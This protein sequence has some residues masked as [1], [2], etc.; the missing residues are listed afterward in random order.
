MPDPPLSVA[1]VGVGGHGA[2]H[3]RRFLQLQAQGLVR[4]AAF[5]EPAPERRP[6]VISALQDAGAAH[7]ADMGAFPDGIEAVVIATPIHL[8]HPMTLAALA[9]GWHVLLEKPAAATIQEWREMVAAERRAARLVAVNFQHTARPGFR[10][11]LG[12][13]RAGRLGRVRRVVGWGLWQRDEVY[14]R[15]AWAGRLRV[16]G[17][18][19]LDGTLMNPFAHLVNQAL[20]LASAVPEEPAMPVAVTAELYHAN[21]IESEDTACARI[22]TGD[23][24]E[25]LIF[26]TLAY[27]GETPPALQ[28][29]GDASA[30]WDYDDRVVVLEAGGG[31]VA[32]ASPPAGPDIVENFLAAVRGNPVPLYSP[33][34]HSEAHLT[35]VNGAFLSAWKP[36]PIPA[37]FVRQ[38]H[39]AEGSLGWMIPE[40]AEHIARARR[41]H[42]LFSELGVPWARPGKRIDVT[43][44]S[45]FAPA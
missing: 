26:T 43:N 4:V 37:H 3:A 40:I 23:G 22:V 20:L 24:V 17:R 39:T 31:E 11:L 42:R 15:R 36:V 14:Y 34:A 5:A 21:P 32:L 9:R 30:I 35:A 38:M 6:A 13:I 2:S 45:E 27:P 7:Y 19:V 44:M 41:E 1:L 18:W 8:H 29:E 12:L 16:D 25:V 10:G 28:I 33:L